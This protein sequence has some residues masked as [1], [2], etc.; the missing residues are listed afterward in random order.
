MS[1][2]RWG[3]RLIPPTRVTITRL[4][5]ASSPASRLRRRKLRPRACS[6]RFAR[7]TPSTWARV[8]AAWTFR[9]ISNTLP[10]TLAAIFWCFLGVVGLVLAIAAAN[11]VNLLLGRAASRQNEMAVRLALGAS[12]WRLI[13]QSATETLLITLLGG[14]AGLVVAPWGLDALVALAPK[15]FLPVVAG[16][17]WLDLRVLGFALAVTLAVGLA[18]GIIPALRVVRLNLGNTLKEGGRGVGREP[19]PRPLAAGL[20]AGEI[21]LS[22]VLLAGALLLIVSLF[23]LLAVRPGFNPEQLWTFRMS[24]PAEKFKTIT[25]AWNFEQQ[26]SDRLRTLPG[27]SQVATASNLPLEWGFNFGI[28]VVD[29]GEKAHVYIMAR[30]V[31]PG[32]FE[33]MGIPVL[34]GRG[35]GDTDMAGSAPVV[36]VNQTLARR[37][38]K[39]RDPLGA[40]P[41]M[42]RARNQTD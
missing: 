30:A 31:S 9:V 39:G 15:D 21:T 26:V 12:G 36:L 1:G 23:D 40:L 24:L 28:D 29:G 41:C 42:V 35:F 20:V 8:S 6:L 2:C 16:Y 25:Q 22:T 5:R 4:L 3:S 10:A 37:F 27:V 17:G 7:I 13:R 14:A 38:A 19:R 33:T 32:Y 11:V 18:T 34:L